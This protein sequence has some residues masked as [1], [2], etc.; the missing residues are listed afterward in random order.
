M[1]APSRVKCRRNLYN[2][3]HWFRQQNA[4]WLLKEQTLSIYVQNQYNPAGSDIQLLSTDLSWGR[5]KAWWVKSCSNKDSVQGNSSETI[6]PVGAQTTK[7]LH[8]KTVTRCSPTQINICIT[9]SFMGLLPVAAWEA[10]VCASGGGL[11]SCVCPDFDER[12]STHRRSAHPC[13]PRPS[14]A[15][16]RKRKHQR[17]NHDQCRW[18]TTD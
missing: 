11:V 10:M 4:D 15:L 16:G 2:V 8:S 13:S 3:P 6:Q 5:I 14:E 7:K 17:E 12:C 9:I 18:I 1:F